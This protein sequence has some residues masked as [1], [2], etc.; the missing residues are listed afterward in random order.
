MQKKL[1]ESL[2]LKPQIGLSILG[3][4]RVGVVSVRSIKGQREFHGQKGEIVLAISQFLQDEMTVADI[5]Q[6][7]NGRF[8]EKL[9][10]EVIDNLLEFAY[11]GRISVKN[12]E[13]EYER[14]IK[15]GRGPWEATAHS[16]ELVGF[17][18]GLEK[19]TRGSALDVGCGTGLDAIFLATCGLKVT[20]VDISLKSIK[21]AKKKARP[22]K[23]DIK[24]I[25]GNILDLKL[26]ARSFSLITDRGCFHHI[27]GNDRLKYANQM[28]RLLKPNGKLILRGYG[29]DSPPPFVPV[30]ESE[31]DAAF[32]KKRFSRGTVFPMLYVCETPSMAN[33]V[34]LTRK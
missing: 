14:V 23:S 25:V 4:S 32:D 19:Q 12:W 16:P 2:V 31:I 5:Y 30:T 20:A 33:F 17:I 6:N 13:K 21:L 9:V 26:P 7:T 34:V 24:W 28:A 11:V 1:S 22:T 8:K 27:A 29:E 18:A 3:P 15:T 10:E